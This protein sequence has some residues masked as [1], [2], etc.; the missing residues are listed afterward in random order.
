[1]E[2]ENNKKLI[3]ENVVSKIER[4]EV[5]MR[6]K[7]YFILKGFLVLGSLFLFFLFALY[8]GSLIVFVFRANNILFFYGTG[9]HGI[10]TVIFSFPWYLVLLSLILIVLLEI[11]SKNFRV[12]YRKPLI[13]SLI[14][15]MILSLTGSVLIDSFSMHDSLFRMAEEKKLPIGGRM[16]R[17]L[18]NLDIENAHFGE[19]LEKENN[20]WTMRLE[21]NEIVSLKITDETRGRR[22]FGEIMEGNNVVVIGELENEEINVW[23]FRRINGHRRNER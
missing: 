7:S 19:I 1:M 12:V 6:S 5:E 9:L 11:I 14:V 18:G 8:V 15:I 2:K 23:G 20:N 13:Y 3:K 10:K 4:G 22:F 17:N 16:Y 21:N